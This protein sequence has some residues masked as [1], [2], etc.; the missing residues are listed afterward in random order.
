MIDGHYIIYTTYCEN[1]ITLNGKIFSKIRLFQFMKC[2][3]V[4]KVLL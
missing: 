3:R 4:L 2:M 1:N